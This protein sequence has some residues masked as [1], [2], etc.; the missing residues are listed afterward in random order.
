MCACVCV[1]VCVSDIKHATARGNRRNHPELNLNQQNY[2]RSTSRPSAH[3]TVPS[4]YQNSH[5]N[6]DTCAQATPSH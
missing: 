5:S 2:S 4:L 6:P 3:S 1:C